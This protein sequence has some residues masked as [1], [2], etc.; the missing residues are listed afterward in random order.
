MICLLSPVLLNPVLC[1]AQEGA[2]AQPPALVRTQTVVATTAATTTDLI[3]TLYFDRISRVS[4]EESA[5]IIQVTFNEGDRVRKGD[6]LIRQDSRILEKELAL[7]K[8]RLAQA[9]I[10]AEKAKRNLDRQTHLFKKDIAPESSYDDQRFDHKDRIQETVVLAREIDILTLR[11]AKHVVRAPFDGIILEKQAEVGE[12]VLPGSQLCMLG[13]TDAIFIQVP[14][15]EHLIRFSTSGDVMPVTLHAS[16]TTL[17]GIVTGI[18]PEADPKTK[19]ISLKLK[20]NYDGPVAVNMSATVAVPV[21]EKKEM[22]MIPRDALVQF[23][24]MDMVFIIADGK[25]KSLPVQVAYSRGANVGVNAEGLTP[26]MTV[27]TEGNER[28]RPG[29]PV[30]VLPPA[31]NAAAENTEEKPAPGSQGE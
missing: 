30:T 15:A 23:Q 31:G 10:R 8:A 3:G 14:V 25:A 27:I 19:N 18:R 1:Q 4:P 13:A 2:P 28:L 17:D 5:R 11:L 12:W 26:G 9:K 29:Q 7:K 24:G 20:L 16:D 6:I 21:S 22:V